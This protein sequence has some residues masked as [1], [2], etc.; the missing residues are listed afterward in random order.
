V[1]LKG[2]G[3]VVAW[4]NDED[5]QTTVPAGLSGVIAVAAG[6]FHSVALKGD[7]TV[8]AWGDNYYG[9]STVPDGLI[10]V[11]AVAAGGGHTV[12]LKSDGT[13]LAWGADYNGQATVPAGL[14]GVTAVAAGY[15]HNVA[16]KG[17]G[18]VVAWGGGATTVP[19]GL[20]GITAVAAG[21][22]HTVALKW[23]GTVVVFGG[24][25]IVPP[26]GINESQVPAT[27]NYDPF[28]ATAT[29]TPVA[30]LQSNQIYTAAVWG[31]SVNGTPMKDEVSWS[32][33]TEGAATV[34]D[35]PTAVTALGGHAR[36]TVTFTAPTNNGGSEITSY[37]VTSSPGGLTATGPASPITVTGLTN[38]TAYTFTVTA[39]NAIGTSLSSTPT[40]SITPADYGNLNSDGVTTSA[41]ALLALQMAVG[42]IPMSAQADVAPLINGIPAPDGKVIA[43]DALVILRKAVGLW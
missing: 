20:A 9:Q 18:T 15:S 5:G 39:A 38:G 4:G 33:T 22:S 25:T 43:A 23:D 12:A 26:I 34:P 31:R 16:L 8:V 35:A 37:I 3:T 2:D 17:D 27:V 1:A 19:A 29:L 7:G 41:D 24:T 30:P 40:N 21:S 11:V 36:A 13:V 10:N 14:T 6:W 42:K 32:F 28:T